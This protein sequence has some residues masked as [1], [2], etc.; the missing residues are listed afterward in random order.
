MDQLDKIEAEVIDIDTLKNAN[1][2]PRYIQ[3]VKVIASG[4]IE[5]AV[6]LQGI[7]LTKGAAEA[8]K[9]AGGTILD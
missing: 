5:K 3:R 9:K 6:K 4:S 8:V 7:K 1:I 2:I